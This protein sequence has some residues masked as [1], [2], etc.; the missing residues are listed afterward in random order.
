MPRPSGSHPIS[1]WILFIAERRALATRNKHIEL[2]RDSQNPLING[3]RMTNVL[4]GRKPV[5]EAILAGQALE[6][7]FILHGSTG[8]AIQDIVAAARQSHVR[9]EWVDRQRL[10]QMTTA[11]NAQG[12]VAQIAEYRYW[13]VS[14]ILD[15]ARERN[16]APFIV[17][18]DG[19]EDPH[20]LGAIIRSAECAG[21]HGVVIPQH[22]AV[23]LTET[24][25]KTAAGALAHIAVAK[26]T[27]LVPVLD[28]LK[29]AGVWIAGTSGEA[30]VSLF[31]ANLTG[32]IAIVIGNEGKGLRRLVRDKCDF[33]VRIP[34]RGKINSLNASV[35]AG[36]TFFEVIR[37]RLQKT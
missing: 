1:F 2:T 5:L 27:N 19:V 8:S 12:V 34:M 36:V 20:N 35:A 17:L 30:E 21:A 28:E 11:E 7:I 9:I 37:Q 4:I 14:E 22:R 31:E 16:E 26:V 32:P 6:K 24:A 29:Q 25:T 18:L 23:G 33:L 10:G 13:E 15:V 3:R